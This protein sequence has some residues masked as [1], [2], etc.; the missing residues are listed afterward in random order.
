MPQS[1][2]KIYVHVVFGTKHR[3]PWLVGEVRPGL[4]AFVGSS[5]KEM[6]CQPI[7]IGGITDHIHLLLRLSKNHALS[8]VIERVKTDS[9]LW[10]KTQ[11]SFFGDFAWQ[12]GYGAFSVDSSRLQIVLNYVSNQ[13]AHHQGLLFKDELGEM[14]VTHGLEYNEKY[15][16]D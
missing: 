16:W 3:I 4:Y 1:L 7:R 9:S 10:I 14:F 5:L 2:A 15:F 8:R 13:E 11:G 6:D 12:N